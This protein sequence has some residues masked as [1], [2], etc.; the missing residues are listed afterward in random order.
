MPRGIQEFARAVAARHRRRDQAETGPAQRLDAGAHRFAGFRE[1][2]RILHDALDQACAPHFEL[3]LDEADEPRRARR[4]AQ[5]VRQHEALRD[6]AD[7]ADD[8][9][10]RLADLFAQ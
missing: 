10:R 2:G 4:E 7:V 8:R 5:D 9:S 6:E 3:R 1:R